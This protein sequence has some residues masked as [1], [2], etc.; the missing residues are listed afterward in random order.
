MG[1]M[2]PERPETRDPRLS[3][4]GMPLW[5]IQT[6]SRHLAIKPSTL[7]SWVVQGRIPAVRIHRLV[8]FRPEEIAEWLAGFRTAP[9]KS[10]GRSA[11]TKGRTEPTAVDRL[12]ARARREVYNDACGETRPT[13]A[14][15]KGETDGAV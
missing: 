11:K 14:H 13:S 2:I 3:D 5:D 10:S 8:R 7:Y 9:P 6:L 15:Q 4:P 12:I 1:H